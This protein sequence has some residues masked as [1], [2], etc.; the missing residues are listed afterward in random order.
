MESRRKDLIVEE[1]KRVS[2]KETSWT[3][4]F[5]CDCASTQ[6]IWMELNSKTCKIR[7]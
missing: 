4:L 6:S 5:A 1:Q 3:W 2:Q 7:T